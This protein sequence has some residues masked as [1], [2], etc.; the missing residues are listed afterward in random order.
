MTPGDLI[1]VCKICRPPES[2][3]VHNKVKKKYGLQK[4]PGGGGRVSTFSP[5]SITIYFWPSYHETFTQC[6]YNVAPVSPGGRSIYLTVLI[7]SRVFHFFPCMKFCLVS[8][9][10]ILT[11]TSL[12][13]T[14]QIEGFP[15]NVFLTNMAKTCVVSLSKSNKLA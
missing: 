13:T 6:R 1:H 5:W 8:E 10:L 7:V 12:C 2:N 9:S 4:Y 14:S 15:G 3:V 11:C